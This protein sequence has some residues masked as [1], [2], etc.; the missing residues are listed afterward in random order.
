VVQFGRAIMSLETS[1]TIS[2]RWRIGLWVMAWVVAA[3][4]TVEGGFE[5]L[6]YGYMFPAGLWT[7]FTPKDWNPPISETILLILGWVMYAGLTVLGLLQKRRSRYFIVFGILCGLLILNVVGC[8][9][10][11]SQIHMSN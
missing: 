8:H 6:I 10:D 9:V 7:L 2:L 3:M 5:L 11:V 4:A 1:K